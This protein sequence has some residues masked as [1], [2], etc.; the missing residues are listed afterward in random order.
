MS[1]KELI[2]SVAEGESAHRAINGITEASVGSFVIMLKNPFGGGK[3]IKK[4][5][6]GS[7]DIEYRFGKEVKIEKGYTGGLKPWK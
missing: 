7:Y 5:S 3:I 1:A 6:D 4:N 2:E